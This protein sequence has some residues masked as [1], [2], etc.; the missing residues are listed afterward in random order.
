MAGNAWQGAQ[1]FIQ[2]FRR[3]DE[4]YEGPRIL[5]WHRSTFSN[6]HAHPHPRF[7]PDGRYVLYSSDLT[8]YSNMYLVPVGDF[9]TL[10]L[11]ETD[12]PA[13]PDMLRDALRYT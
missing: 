7:T 1:P 10:P 12:T 11:L 6:Q 3:R 4:G 9:E 13:R 8:D 5:A 2:L